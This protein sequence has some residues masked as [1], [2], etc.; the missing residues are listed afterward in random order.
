MSKISKAL[1]K[2]KKEQNLTSAQIYNLEDS[3][4]A[5]ESRT[6]KNPK[7]TLNPDARPTAT[8][9]SAQKPPHVIKPILEEAKDATPS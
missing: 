4:T 6:P 2:Y 9:D 8:P 7:W 5:K 1:E 3:Q